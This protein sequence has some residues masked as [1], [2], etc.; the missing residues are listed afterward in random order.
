MLESEALSPMAARFANAVNDFGRGAS[1]AGARREAQGT[2]DAASGGS[3]IGGISES[4]QLPTFS[5]QLSVAPQAALATPRNRAHSYI[6][7]PRP[8]DARREYFAQSSDE[9]DALDVSATG[10]AQH[11]CRIAL[12]LPQYQRTHAKGQPP[13]ATVRVSSTMDAS[14]AGSCGALPG[15]LSGS[16]GVPGSDASFGGWAGTRVESVHM[17]PSFQRPT[18]IRAIHDALREHSGDDAAFGSLAL[19]RRGTTAADSFETCDHG[20]FMSAAMGGVSLRN[21]TNLA[22]VALST[23]L[24]EWSVLEDRLLLTLD[25]KNLDVVAGYAAA[26]AQ[27]PVVYPK[28][29][30]ASNDCGVKARVT[31]LRV[32]GELHKRGQLL[33]QLEDSDCE[34]LINIAMVSNLDT[35][36]PSSRRGSLHDAAVAPQSPLGNASFNSPGHASMS[37]EDF[38][39]SSQHALGKSRAPPNLV[40]RCVTRAHA[41][42]AREAAAERAQWAAELNKKKPSSGV[43]PGADSTSNPDQPPALELSPSVVDDAD[44]VHTPTPADTRNDVFCRVEDVCPRAPFLAELVQEAKHT[45]AQMQSRTPAAKFNKTASSPSIKQPPT[46]VGL[47]GVTR[48]V[49]NEEDAMYTAVPSMHDVFGADNV[50]RFVAFCANPTIVDDKIDMQEAYSATAAERDAAAESI[51]DAVERKRQARSALVNAN[52]DVECQFI[53]DDTERYF[54]QDVQLL[55]ALYDAHKHTECAKATARR[56]AQLEELGRFFDMEAAMLQHVLLNTRAAPV[57]ATG[58]IAAGRHRLPCAVTKDE[59]AALEQRCHE[60]LPRYAT[61]RMLLLAELLACQELRS[62]CI[63][64]IASNF[65]HF[66]KDPA[67]HSPAIRPCTYRELMTMVSLKDLIATCKRRG[68]VMGDTDARPSETRAA[69][70]VDNTK[71]PDQVGVPLQYLEEEY[72]RRRMIV[73]DDLRGKQLAVL[74]QMA[75]ALATHAAEQ[76]S[77]HAEQ[78]RRALATSDGVAADVSQEA[79]PGAQAAAGGLGPVADFDATALETWAD[80]IH[81]ALADAECAALGAP[82]TIACSTEASRGDA[83]AESPTQVSRPVGRDAA[84]AGP[85]DSTL[86][87]RVPSSPPALAAV[88]VALDASHPAFRVVDLVKPLTQVSVAAAPQ[89]HDRQARAFRVRRRCGEA[90]LKHCFEVV[91]PYIN[92]NC[93]TAAVIGV[94]FALDGA[95]DPAPKPANGRAWGLESATAA[96]ANSL[97]GLT[98]PGVLW[99]SSGL[100]YLNGAVHGFSHGCNFDVG[101][102]LRV[103]LDEL[104]G[105]VAFFRNGRP[106]AAPTHSRPGGDEAA[107][108]VTDGAL[109]GRGPFVPVV[110]LYSP[111]PSRAGLPSAAVVPSVQKIGA[112]LSLEHTC[113]RVAV[114]LD[115]PW[116]VP[117]V[118]DAPAGAETASAASCSVS[119][120]ASAQQSPMRRGA[121]CVDSTKTGAEPYMSFRAAC[122]AL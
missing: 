115:G 69:R 85:G 12:A 53:S 51:R 82:A 3:R 54:E 7:P 39:A 116:L 19:S 121:A 106:V 64:E 37:A 62:A 38:S 15:V 72:R 59:L 94:G 87:L 118:R 71:Q 58:Q 27:N 44:D 73:A 49:L 102:T 90:V 18:Y 95:M 91:V 32:G 26:H 11:V 86:G 100:L 35:V 30:K 67:L 24:A 120:T 92:A 109:A 79:P 20:G 36:T 77:M 41:A 50:A 17:S 1:P 105:T 119:A 33:A 88:S 14:P 46:P 96:A 21:D 28:A 13:T 57:V 60:I 70:K 114:N 16:F 45:Q 101:D 76:R 83:A 78:Q 31:K 47:A 34:R 29:P 98:A 40:V 52:C 84:Q 9:G 93:R 104:T 81:S 42:K 99:L 56:D 65:I 107:T 112:G 110:T 55:R 61:A 8:T 25:G 66:A 80:V 22:D 111:V 23:A 48:V 68:V 74:Q 6:V 89:S 2:G 108:P 63:T 4:T 103:A 10:N 117:L 97:P 5:E 113:V 122:T 43:A 75:D